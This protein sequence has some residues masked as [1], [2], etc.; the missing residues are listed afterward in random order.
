MLTMLMLTM[1]TMLTMA[2]VMWVA[3]NRFNFTAKNNI[4]FTWATR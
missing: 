4:G 1:L 2:V 3:R